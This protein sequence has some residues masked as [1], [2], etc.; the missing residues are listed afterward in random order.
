MLIARA[1]V[2]S[3]KTSDKQTASPVA[4]PTRSFMVSIL[5][6]TNMEAIVRSRAKLVTTAFVN[7]TTLMPLALLLCS[8]LDLRSFVLFSC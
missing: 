1:F 2:N 5:S 3:D 8:E 7:P 4:A 6:K